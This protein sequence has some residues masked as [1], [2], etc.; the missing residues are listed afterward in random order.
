MYAFCIIQISISWSSPVALH[1]T[2]TQLPVTE[3][4]YTERGK[5]LSPYLRQHTPSYEY[6]TGQSLDPAWNYLQDI[7][8]TEQ[9]LENLGSIPG[10][11]NS[12]MPFKSLTQEI[13]IIPEKPTVVGL[14]LILLKLDIHC[15]VHKSSALYQNHCLNFSFTTLVTTKLRPPKLILLFMF[16]QVSPS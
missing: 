15:R 16:S 10:T 11:D 4:S 14:V 6:A 9:L 7:K 1:D 2:A 3:H 5:L 12:N 13:N 8:P